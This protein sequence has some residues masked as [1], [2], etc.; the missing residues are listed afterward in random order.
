MRLL[1][2]WGVK[3]ENVKKGAIVLSPFSCAS[4]KKR[5]KGEKT[6]GLQKSL[7]ACNKSKF[8]QSPTLATCSS[9][10]VTHPRIIWQQQ[11]SVFSEMLPWTWWKRPWWFLIQPT[12]VVESYLITKNGSFRISVAACFA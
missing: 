9:L 11:P 6:N 3:Q 12:M 4:L 1:V 5:K 8:T 2:S 7:L 10:L